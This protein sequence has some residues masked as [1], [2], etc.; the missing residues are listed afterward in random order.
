MA[1]AL[2]I[3]SIRCQKKKYYQSLH[4][5]SC[6]CSASYQHKENFLALKNPF[7]L[8]FERTTNSNKINWCRFFII[9]HTFGHR[10]FILL[11]TEMCQH[12]NDPLTLNTTSKLCC[13]HTS[14][15]YQR[16][17]QLFQFI[18]E[19][20]NEKVKLLCWLWN[21]PIFSACSKTHIAWK[22]KNQNEN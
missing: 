17:N 6:G 8:D 11:W 21:G 19:A 13:S 7:C 16:S 4:Y 18:F 3:F 15:I 14:P 9:T 20:P 10:L 5:R 2:F 22:K 12:Q 1:H